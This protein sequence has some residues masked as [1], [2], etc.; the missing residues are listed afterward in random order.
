MPTSSPTEATTSFLEA[1]NSGNVEAILSH[2]APSA[3][4]VQADGQEVRGEQALRE[5]LTGFMAMKPRLQFH[6]AVSITCGDLASNIGQWT[7][8]GTGPEGPV[9]MEGRGFDVMQRQA[10]G[11]W[12]MVIDNPWGDAVLG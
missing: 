7:L 6:K 12:K 5:T 1:F 11:S 8:E 10:D 3:V 4:F 2:Y 9:K